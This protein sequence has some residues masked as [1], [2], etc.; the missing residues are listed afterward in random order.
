MV[1]WSASSWAAALYA[2]P[3]WLALCRQGARAHPAADLGVN[4]LWVA[5]AAQIL[6]HGSAR[7]DRNRRQVIAMVQ[8]CSVSL[9]AVGHYFNKTGWLLSI[10]PPL[11]VLATSARARVRL[12][13]LSR[14][15]WSAICNIFGLDT[16]YAGGP[17]S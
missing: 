17:R 9:S 8:H 2:G 16:D 3:C 5:L 4:L 15:L 7:A 12:V 11:V 13:R 1:A 14:Y 6:T 10:G